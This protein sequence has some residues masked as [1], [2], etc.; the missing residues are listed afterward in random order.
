[1]CEKSEIGHKNF[2]EPNIYLKLLVSSDQ[3]SRIQNDIK[4]T[5]LEF[6]WSK[7]FLN[8]FLM[9]NPFIVSGLDLFYCLNEDLSHMSF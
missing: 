3:L 4:Q 9:I 1:M 7:Y 5:F 2:I 8:N 6:C